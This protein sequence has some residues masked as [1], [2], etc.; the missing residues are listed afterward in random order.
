MNTKKLAAC[1]IFVVLSYGLPT[2]ATA[3]APTDQMKST[4]DA[5]LEILK[6][7]SLDEA[8]K[9][10]KVKGLIADRFDFRNM[11]QRVLATNWKKATEEQ[12]TRF[13]ELFPEILSNVYM[14]RIQGYTNERI[15][16]VGETIK[17]E[18]FALVE[19]SIVSPSVEIPVNYKLRLKSE[20]WLVY[21]VVIE[22][23]SLINTY[24]SSYKE[25]AK[26]EGID[27]LLARMEEKLSEG[28]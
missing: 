23:V 21:D 6:D 26:N 12:Q 24:R 13:S 5:V 22:G 11:S 3:G 17:K 18:K 10:T 2:A 8:A 16:Y 7:E 14:G 9:D 19:T 27:G 20:G 1:L 4:I 15:D 28:A 25:I